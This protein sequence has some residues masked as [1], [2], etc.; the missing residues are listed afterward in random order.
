[1][2]HETAISRVY[3]YDT[4]DYHL[5][6]FLLGKAKAQGPFLRLSIVKI[7]EFAQTFENNYAEREYYGFS[8]C[9]FV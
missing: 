1:M 4:R 9:K 8:V 7:F 2:Q 3:N 5:R 6:V